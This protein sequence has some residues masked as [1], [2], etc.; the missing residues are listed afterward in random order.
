MLFRKNERKSRGTCV[1][2]TFGALAAIGAFTVAKS[3]KDAV[4][5]A[6]DSVKKI[7]FK[8]KCTAPVEREDCYYK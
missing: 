2:L 5:K 1:I 4:C 7:L 8:S 3:G 6:R